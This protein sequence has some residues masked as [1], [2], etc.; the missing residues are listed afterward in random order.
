M[1]IR[2]DCQA[3]ASTLLAAIRASEVFLPR[4]EHITLWLEKF[5][6]RTAISGAEVQLGERED[7]AALEQFFRSR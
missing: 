7:L 6:T 5:V 3:R 2:A 4:R 1:S